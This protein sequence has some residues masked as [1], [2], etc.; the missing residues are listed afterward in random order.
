MS[1]ITANHQFDQKIQI[2][3]R[4]AFWKGVVLSIS[5]VFYFGF[6]IR[7]LFL[8]FA[9]YYEFDPGFLGDS[10]ILL[11]LIPAS[12]VLGYLWST[13]PQSLGRILAEK[14]NRVLKN[15]FDKKTTAGWIYTPSGIFTGLVLL[16]TA[17][18]GVNV[19]GMSIRKLFEADGFNGAINI[20]S[21]ILSPNWGI[22]DLV[23]TYMVE[24]IFIALMATL[25]AVPIAFT[26]SFFAAKN[27]MRES[28]RTIGVYYLVRLIANFTRSVEP[29]VWAIIFS[30]WVGVGPFAGSMALMLHSVASLLKLYSEQIENIDHG[31][32]EAIEATGAN[33]IQVVWY[34]VVPQIVLPFL[35]FTIYRWDINVRM[36]T[37]IGLVGGGG[38]GTLLMQYQGLAKW[39]EVGTAVFAI[40][41]VVWLMD[42]MSAKVREAIY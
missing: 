28:R 4:W 8:Q 33:R 22:L 7:Y 41:A 25:I 40:A 12:V 21:K 34:A 29:L 1:E 17:A 23:L 19:T 31:P 5:M 26:L 16:V 42:T 36:A 27:L 39:N 15:F 32:V 11:Y 13:S 3:K 30:V 24:T 10:T 14:T 6:A 9:D 37:V 2:E 18:I 35:S 20:F 38:V